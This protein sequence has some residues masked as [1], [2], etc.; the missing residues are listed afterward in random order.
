MV[1]RDDLRLTCNHCRHLLARSMALGCNRQY[2]SA[3]IVFIYVPKVYIASSSYASVH[4]LSLLAFSPRSSAHCSS[5]EWQAGTTAGKG[6]PRFRGQ[7]Y[8]I[9]LRA[10]GT[11]GDQEARRPGKRALSL[12]AAFSL[13]FQDQPPPQKR[14]R[15][16]QHF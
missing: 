9:C 6:T 8:D 5:A 3:T 1:A 15:K 2:Y 13:R 16:K 10:G 7:L 11:D 14:V 4:K 12:A